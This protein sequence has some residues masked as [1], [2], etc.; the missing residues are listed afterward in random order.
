MA[1][2]IN[3]SVWGTVPETGAAIRL[4]PNTLGTCYNNGTFDPDDINAMDKSVVPWGVPYCGLGGMSYLKKLRMPI[5]IPKSSYMKA[6]TL[7]TFEIEEFVGTNNPVILMSVGQ[8]AASNENWF[9][10][11][12][13]GAVNSS[14]TAF[15]SNAAYDRD[16]NIPAGTAGNA[17]WNYRPIVYLDYQK[18]IAQ[19]NYFILWD[20]VGGT[21][22]RAYNL[23]NYPA[24][25]RTWDDYE[26]L[27][28]EY[29]IY[30]RTVN[31]AWTPNGYYMAI[32]INEKD[33]SKFV[34]DRYFGQEIRP[35]KWAPFSYRNAIKTTFYGS[36]GGY[37]IAST[38]ITKE[39]D[40]ETLFD[41][42][43]WTSE[44]ISIG[45][46]IDGSQTFDNIS[47]TMEKKCGFMQGGVWFEIVKGSEMPGNDNNSHNIQMGV[48]YKIKDYEP[49]TS[50]AAAWAKIIA[51]EMAFLGLPF[52]IKLSGDA[53]TPASTVTISDDDVFLPIFDMDHMVTTGRY[54]TELAEKQTLPNYTWENIFDSTIPNW[55]SSYNP[56]K[57]GPGPGPGPG[58]DPN[59]N[60]LYPSNPGFS[61]ASAGGKCYALVDG[62]IDTIF[63]EIYG[64]DE[65]SWLDLISG[66]SLYGAD[67]M[68]AIISYKWYPWA[69]NFTGTAGLYLGGIRI[70]NS[71]YEVPRTDAEALHTE[72]ASFYY[73]R[74][75]NFINSR[76]SQ[77]RL[78]LPFYGFYA[79]PQQKFIS[80]KLTVDFHYNLPDEVGVWIISFDDVI[81]DFVECQCSIDVPLSA[82]DYRGQ[83]YAAISGILSTAGNL[84]NSVGDVAK[85]AVS[86]GI[87]S[88]TAAGAA[89]AYHVDAGESVFSTIRKQGVGALQAFDGTQRMQIGM[90]GSGAT[91]AAG[92]AIGVGTS[93]LGGVSQGFNDVMSTRRTLNQMKINLP[94]HGAASPTTFLN[95]PMFPFVQVYTNNTI[96]DYVGKDSQ[97]KLKN[98]HA[99]DKWVTAS[100]MPSN[101]LCQAS[102]IADMDTSGMELSEVEELN[103]ILQSGFFI[104]IE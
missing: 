102:G 7:T 65:D 37:T 12:M 64:R 19:V 71:A 33:T 46:Y 57:P 30:Y 48:Y 61:L 8:S 23:D 69:W 26:L 74:E 55:D 14:E 6:G 40:S 53:S 90:M 54:T 77:A 3:E 76:H 100:E 10:C 17:M 62:T 11:R 59:P 70:G 47:Y 92:G 96:D 20:R 73:G 50:K 18:V 58:P 24:S 89:S 32:P 36:T 67:P 101:S 39:A 25:G 91:Q 16:G 63:E 86:V 104:A 29:S 103:S 52:Q 43:N 2:K 22:I 51:H 1:T 83:K 81:Y 87:G 97:Y 35:Q 41:K 60:P 27:G 99:C 4:A 72:N 78:W 93:F 56:P 88:A 95:L 68:A 79:L 38:A 31:N 15:T 9:S 80:E 34:L 82:T 13:S 42:T 98:G 49:G 28:F 85:S 44:L 45:N 84:I 5:P 66:L 21:R 94:Y 75:K